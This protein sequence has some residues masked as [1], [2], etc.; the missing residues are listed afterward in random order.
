VRTDEAGVSRRKWGLFEIGL[1]IKKGYMKTYKVQVKDD[2]IIWY[3]PKTNK[4]H[5]EDGPAVEY[6]DGD[7]AWYKNGKLHRMERSIS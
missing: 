3:H 2:C 4:R 6:A 7:K 1:E 5:R